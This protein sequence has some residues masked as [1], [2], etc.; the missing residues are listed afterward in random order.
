MLGCIRLRI[1]C[2]SQEGRPRL[3]LWGHFWVLG[4]KKDVDNSER[5]LK[6]RNKNEAEKA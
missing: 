2:K 6:E 5:R 3:E 1:M 4:L